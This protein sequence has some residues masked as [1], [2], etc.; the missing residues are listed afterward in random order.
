VL[1]VAP[2]VRVVLSAPAR[3]AGSVAVIDYHV[4]LLVLT[5]GEEDVT[6]GFPAFG[7]DR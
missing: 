4:S 2:F 1:F 5:Q 6:A 3:R 7:N